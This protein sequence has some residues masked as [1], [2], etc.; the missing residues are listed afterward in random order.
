MADAPLAARFAA[1]P[2]IRQWAQEHGFSEWMV[3]RLVRLTDNP[4]ALLDGLLRRPPRYLRVNPLRG[5]FDEVKVRLEARGFELSR[6]DLDPRIM[7]VRQAPISPGATLEHMLGMTTLQDLASASAPLAVAARPGDVVADLAAA[8]GV[9]TLHVAGDLG[10]KGAVV[11]V[12]PDRDRMRALRFNLERGGAT[13]ALLRLHEAQALPGEAWADKV[14]LDAP[15]TGEGTIPKDKNRRFAKP[16]EIPK[17]CAVQAEILDAADRVLKPGGRLVYA[18]C[19][20]GPEEN[21]AQVQRML[22]KGYRMEAL[23]FDRCGGVPLAPG[24]T[25]WPGFTLDQELRLAR[26]FV[27]GVH[28]TLGFFVAAL[29]KGGGA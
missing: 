7:R 12:E 4:N 25:E 3:A 20:F 27:P 15:C 24:V 14:L 11:A 28:P 16:E 19:T 9:K 21:E 5:D 29:R 2:K 18:T 17:L 1:G 8:P 23:P 22:A 26:R 13:T 6:S 10:A